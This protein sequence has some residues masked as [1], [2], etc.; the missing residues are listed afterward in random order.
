MLNEVVTAKIGHGEAAI[1]DG[2]GFWPGK[3]RISIAMFDAP[4]KDRCIVVTVNGKRVVVEPLP[5]PTE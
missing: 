2:K 4:G 3:C 1:I 5:G